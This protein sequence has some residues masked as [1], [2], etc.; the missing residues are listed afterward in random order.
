MSQQELKIKTDEA[1]IEALTIELNVYKRQIEGAKIMLDSGVLSLSDFEKRK[2]N[3]QNGL[4]KITSANNKLLQD[5]Q[6]LLNLQIEQNAAQQEYADKI[7]KTA[8]DKFA[9]LSSAASTDA[10]IAKLRNQ[11][12]S[13]DARNNLYFITAPQSGQITKAKKAGIGELLKEGETLLEMV[14]DKIQYAVEM[15]IEPMDLPLISRGQKVRFVF[16]GF[17]AIVFSGWPA[18]SFGTFGGKVSAIENSAGPNGKFRVLV[19]EDPEDRPWPQRLRMGGGASGIALLKNVQIYYELW[20]NING[21][22]P[23]YYVTDDEKPKTKK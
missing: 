20:R 17:P 15:Y 6:E 23:D 8:G 9:S 4:A 7:A 5:K 14:P 19:T 12:A 18:N 11:Y 22:P 13:Y 3:Y 16:D 21:F 2:V 1:D 10:E